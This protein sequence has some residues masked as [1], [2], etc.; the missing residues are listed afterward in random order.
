MAPPSEPFMLTPLVIA[1]PEP[2]ADR[3]RAPGDADRLRRHRP[4]VPEPEGWAAYG[5]PEWG[6]FRLGKTNPN[7]STSGLSALIAQTYAA[8]G[9]TRAS[10]S[11]SWPGPTWSPSARGSSRASCTTATSR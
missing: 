9:T 7:F 6:P 4:A 1:M 3:P 11:R 8:T 2:M 10:A 5:H